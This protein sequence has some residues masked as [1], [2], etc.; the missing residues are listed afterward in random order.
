[1]MTLD[2]I[3]LPYRFEPLGEAYLVRDKPSID[4]PADMVR[5]DVDL[6][7]KIRIVGYRLGSDRLDPGDTL[8][9]D[10]A[11]QPL[12]PLERD[13]AFFVHVQDEALFNAPLSPSDTRINNRGRKLKNEIIV[14]DQET[15]N[16]TGQNK[17]NL[18]WYDCSGIDWDEGWG[19]SFL[20][21]K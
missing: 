8:T 10:I 9:I 5:V 1:M 19:R 15:D 3:D 21:K 6:D 12:V 7:E 4:V 13:Y 14:M 16:G 11:W 20:P 17:G 2:Y 18:R